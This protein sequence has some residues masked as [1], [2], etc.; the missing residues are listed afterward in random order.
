MQSRQDP[1]SGFFR[2]P[3]FAKDYSD[4][5]LNRAIGMAAGAMRRCGGEALY[6][7]P[8]ERIEDS[9]EAAKHYA[10]L[11]SAETLTAWLDQLP[12]ERR[13]WT[14]GGTVL[15][16]S[17]V[18]KTMEEPR[19]TQLLKVFADYLT[20]KQA[21]DGYYGKNDSWFSRLSGTY[22]LISF[23]ESNGL[24]IPKIPELSASTLKHLQST[25]YDNLIVL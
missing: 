8:L 2:D 11:A 7:V 25:P 16:Q 4:N 19:R 10:Y 23:L 17:S 13:I 14:V 18:F 20:S 22:K 21:D 5:T 3:E 9:P 12:W 15:A 1:K 6:P 24:T